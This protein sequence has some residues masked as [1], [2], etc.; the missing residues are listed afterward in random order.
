MGQIAFVVWREAVEALLIVGVLN[1]W[2]THNAA[3]HAARAGRLALW[4]GVVAGLAL[5]AGL[6]AILLFSSELFGDEGEDYFQAGMALGA[7]GLILQMVVWSQRLSREWTAQ[8]QQGV[9]E[10]VR[11]SNWVGVGPLAALAV[12]REGAETVVF[13]YGNFAGAE[14]GAL[15]FGVVAAAL[16]LMAAALTYLLIQLGSR[17]VS[18]RIFFAATEIVLLLVAA[19]LLM[20]GIDRLIGLGI[21]P[22]LT[23]PLWD[24]TG[25]L[26]DGRPFGSLVSSLT[27]YRARPDLMQILAYCAFWVLAW[28][29]TNRRRYATLPKTV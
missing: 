8:L 19:A 6:A 22:S 29:V 16:G 7:A 12:A 18:W 25:L 2:L 23:P 28:L 4:A 26:D 15:L 9:A 3:G 17:Y 5:A 20:T 14:A 10:A 11:R 13:L 1:A 27:G 24:S 21:L